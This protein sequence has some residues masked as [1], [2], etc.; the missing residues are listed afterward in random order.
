MKN[1]FIVL[2]ILCTF[3]SCGKTNYS[4]TYKHNPNTTYN[5][6]RVGVEKYK[7]N[8]GKSKK[9]KKYKIGINK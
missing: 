3:S 1:I 6:T 9:T 5:T 8:K 2:V 7:A 4:C